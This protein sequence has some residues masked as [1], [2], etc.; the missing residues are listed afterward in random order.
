MQVSSVP[1]KLHC[2]LYWLTK[3]QYTFTINLKSHFCFITSKFPMYWQA[4]SLSPIITCMNYLFQGRYKLLEK[5]K[6]L[7][8]SWAKPEDIW[9]WW[10]RYKKQNT[11]WCT[12]SLRRDRKRIPRALPHVQKPT[13]TF[14]SL[15]STVPSPLLKDP[16]QQFSLTC[17]IYFS[18]STRS[19][20]WL[21]LPLKQN[22]KRKDPLSTS[23]PTSATVQFLFSPF[24]WNFSKKSASR[25]N[26][27]LL[28]LFPK[29]FT[30]PPKQIKN[31]G[32]ASMVYSQSSFYLLLCSVWLP[33]LW[34]FSFPQLLKLCCP[35]SLWQSL[36]FIFSTRLFS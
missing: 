34:T 17:T 2:S 18:F 31:W 12:V 20:P 15:C 32:P 14:P 36:G 16:P 23:I 35:E 5:K 10:L 25:T 7:L 8:N 3:A 28:P 4:F 21:F 26:L 29:P 9:C 1:T 11:R 13:S 24:R 19:F 33:S 27:T 30:N 22:N 6:C